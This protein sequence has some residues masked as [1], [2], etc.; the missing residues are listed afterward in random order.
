MEN[1]RQHLQLFKSTVENLPVPTSILFITDPHIFKNKAFDMLFDTA[2][3]RITP[4]ALK[5]FYKIPETYEHALQSA[6][7]QG[8]WSDR[9]EMKTASGE[10]IFA[11]VQVDALADADSGEIMAY[12]SSYIDLLEEQKI[13]K[14]YQFQKEYLSTLHAISIGMFRR[15]RLSDLLNAVILR[16][17]KLTR[18]PNGFLYIYNQAT[19]EL[20]V[21]AACGN[22]TD[23][24]GY[25]TRPGEGLAGKIFQNGEPLILENY[26]TWPHRLD[27]A[28]VHKIFAVIG[29][30][31]ISGSKTE[32][33]IG[34]CC[35]TPDGTIDP[36]LIPVL[37]EFSAIAQIAIDNTKLSER[38]KQE[39]EKRIALEKERKEMEHRLNQ[40]QRMESIGTLAGGI[41]H[42]FNNILSAIMG[43]TQIAQLEARKGSMLEKDLNEIY[44][45]SLRAKDLVQQILTF[46]RQSDDQVSPIRIDLI[47]KE[48]LKF[49]RSSIPTTISIQQFITTRSEVLANPTKIYQV[50]LNLFTNAAQAMNKSAGTLTVE[51]KDE[52][53][54]S[55]MGCLAPG[56]YIRADISDTGIGI[57]E[58]NLQN[59]FEPYFTT[60]PVNEGT[61]L[62]LSVVHGVMKNMGG[63]IFVKSVPD[64]KTTFTLFFPVAQ[65]LSA[66]KKPLR[67]QLYHLPGKGEHILFVDDEPSIASV[68]KRMLEAL[69]FKVTAL[70]SSVKALAHFAATPED[71]HAVVTDMTMPEMTGEALAGELKKIRQDIPVILCTG[72]HQF[73]SDTAYQKKGIDYLCSKPMSKETLG[74]TVRKAIDAG[75]ANTSA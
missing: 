10:P 72:H 60:K 18:I 71:F 21:A 9:I 37:E 75:P 12:T 52:A 42:D 59:I 29:I 41:A 45:A 26:Q 15:L 2:G 33:V 28:F 44:T 17:S 3:T 65:T 8:R 57:A 25:T 34:L 58:E 51:M 13:E 30:P 7:G 61:G 55:P 74:Q 48:V 39:L 1:I 50:F 69:N 64:E 73:G 67:D 24:I 62:G 46:A 32:G 43:F 66:E 54:A 70:S 47:T 16:A 36:E 6:A 63:D 53:I 19:H 11:L 27:N 49:I 56:R 40:S 5:S 68:G 38:L 22:M 31:L 14:E 20:T 23:A 4:S 35:D